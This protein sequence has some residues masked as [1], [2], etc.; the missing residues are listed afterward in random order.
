MKRFIIAAA[1]CTVIMG[2]EKNTGKEDSVDVP[3]T[4]TVSDNGFS[5]EDGTYSNSRTFSAGDRI[6]LF[7]LMNGEILE[8]FNNICLTASGTGDAIVWQAADPEMLFPSGAEYYAY[9]PYQE[10]LP[11]SVDL[12]ASDAAGFFSMISEAW[13]VASDQSGDGFDSSDLLIGMAAPADNSLSLGMSHAM[14]LVEISLPGTFYTFTNTDYDIPDYSL[15]GLRI[16]FDSK[17]PKSKNGR[18]LLVVE[19]GAFSIPC[20]YSG[21]SKTYDG[22]AEAGKCTSF[23][24]GEPTVIEHNLQ[25]GDFFLADGNLLSKDAP[26]SEVGSANVIGLVCQI[27]PERIGNGE[28]EW[29]LRPGVPE[30]VDTPAGIR[31][32]RQEITRGMNPK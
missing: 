12:T 19:P 16:S 32:T 27:D 11:A 10:T 26:A 28:K 4:I 20:T 13:P 17:I 1:V 25:I 14:G 30:M 21:E 22:N 8:G 5:M 18:F 2:C 6:G 24:E 23:S 7:A 3:L 9:W 29:S 15:S 31:T